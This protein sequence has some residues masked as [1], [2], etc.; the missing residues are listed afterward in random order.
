MTQKKRKTRSDWECEKQEAI[1]AV[2]LEERKVIG[3]ELRRRARRLTG[4]T[5]HEILSALDW[6]NS[7]IF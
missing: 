2:L 1:R 3:D 6:V 7:R 4:E 5:Q